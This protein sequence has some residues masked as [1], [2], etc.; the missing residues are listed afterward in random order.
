M[1][2]TNERHKPQHSSANV[3]SDRT[4]RASRGDVPIHPVLFLC[5]SGMRVADLAMDIL[6]A[7]S[8]FPPYNGVHLQVRVGLH[9]GPM[10]AGVVGSRKPKWTLLGD[11]MNVGELKWTLLGDVMKCR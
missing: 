11:A 4:S 3:L 8:Q 6:E 1:R 5:R 2:I 7:M 9:V 10:V